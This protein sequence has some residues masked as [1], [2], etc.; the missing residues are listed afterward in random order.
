MNN[1]NLRQLIQ[2]KELTQNLRFIFYYPELKFFGAKFGANIRRQKEHLLGVL[3]LKI[4]IKTK[5]PQTI[6]VFV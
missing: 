3:N 6:N 2:N 5:N 1:L 4:L